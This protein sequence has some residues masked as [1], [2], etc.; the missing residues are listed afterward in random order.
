MNNIQEEALAEA[1]RSGS[2][3]DHRLAGFTWERYEED[4]LYIL[5]AFLPQVIL[6]ELDFYKV[7]KTA[8]AAYLDSDRKT[9]NP[10][11]ADG[12]LENL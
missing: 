4:I 6:G 3:H 7:L 11:W 1:I 2:L 8:Q 5:D 10:D 9:F 12:I